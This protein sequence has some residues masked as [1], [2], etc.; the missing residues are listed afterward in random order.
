MP[1]LVLSILSAIWV[2][3]QDRGDVALEDLALRQQSAVL[4]RKQ[5]R[6]PLNALDRLLWTTP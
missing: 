3:F 4:K 5:P 2:F 1:E 6:P